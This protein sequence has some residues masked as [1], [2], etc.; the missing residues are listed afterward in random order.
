MF[1]VIIRPLAMFWV[2]KKNDL[3]YQSIC[4]PL[5]LLKIPQVTILDDLHCLKGSCFFWI[6]VQSHCPGKVPAKLRALSPLANRER[7][8]T[9]DLDKSQVRGGYNCV[10]EIRRATVSHFVLSWSEYMLAPFWSKEIALSRF[11]VSHVSVFNPFQ[12]VIDPP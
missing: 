11:S 7:M 2:C 8:W 10:R 1:W 5:W 12:Q 4:H 3:F 9:F 6:L